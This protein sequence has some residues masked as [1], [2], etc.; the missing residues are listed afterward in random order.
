MSARPPHRPGAVCHE[1]ATRLHPAGKLTWLNDGMGYGVIAVA[2]IPKGTI[3]WVLDPLDQ[4]LDD[5]R[6]RALGDEYA[7]ILEKY[8]YIDGQGA[9]I[10]C[11]DFGRFMNHSCAAN[12]LSPGLPFEIAVR[13]IRPGEELTSDYASINLERPFRCMCGATHCR[14]II[15]PEDFEALRDDWDDLVREAFPHIADVPQPLWKR[16]R[17]HRTIAECIANPKLIPTIGWHRWHGD[18]GHI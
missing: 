13:D 12:T 8:T 16:I 2:P 6:V 14:G 1:E 10:L 18:N 7:P 4:I 9:R 15:R 11:W 3:T 5:E 17:D